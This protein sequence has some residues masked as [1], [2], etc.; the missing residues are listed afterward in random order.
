MQFILHI[1]LLCLL[2]IVDTKTDL[3]SIFISVYDVNLL[4]F[5]S[6]LLVICFVKLNLY[7]FIIDLS[8][9]I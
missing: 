8:I 1:C 2:L 3:K 6:N 5:N 7:H 9:S 4:L